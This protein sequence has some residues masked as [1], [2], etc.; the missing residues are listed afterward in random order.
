MSKFSANP[1]DVVDALQIIINVLGSTI[2]HVN[3]VPLDD[4]TSDILMEEAT[5]KFQAYLAS[6]QVSDKVDALVRD[7]WAYY[8]YAIDEDD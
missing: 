6:H 8:R 2:R 7:L 4:R 3:D 5:K 1:R